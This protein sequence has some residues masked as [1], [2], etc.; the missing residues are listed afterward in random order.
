M[1]VPIK[2]RLLADPLSGFVGFF[3]KEGWVSRGGY[4][5]RIYW[6]SIPVY[7]PEVGCL[8][9]LDATT[10]E[11]TTSFMEM[12]KGE[13]A[14][15][16]LHNFEP[17]WRRAVSWGQY[18]FKPL[19]EL[20]RVYSI[21]LFLD[22]ALTPS[23]WT[24][25]AMFS[26]VR[27]FPLECHRP[28]WFKCFYSYNLFPAFINPE[29]RKQKKEV[30]LG[31]S[32]KIVPVEVQEIEF[33]INGWLDS[34]KVY[35][36]FEEEDFEDFQKWGS[37]G[38]YFCLAEGFNSYQGGR[39]P[40]RHINIVRALYPLVHSSYDI[41]PLLFPKVVPE[42]EDLIIRFFIPTG[43]LVRILHRLEKFEGVR[44]TFQLE[45]SSKLYLGLAKVEEKEGKTIYE[46]VNPALVAILIRKA[47]ES[48]VETTVAKEVL[49]KPWEL[50]DRVKE[51][52]KTKKDWKID[53]LLFGA[54][55]YLSIKTENSSLLRYK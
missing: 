47:L 3:E 43:S 45:E 19:G 44:G 34:K 17:S 1:K 2:Q 28:L 4:P 6:A 40:G 39:S 18:E 37:A 30:W 22:F 41:M 35:L 53:L 48:R 20:E 55:E 46:A 38:Y 8:I 27:Y 11:I 52:E 32:I 50:M 24:R 23:V 13:V 42:R 29:K 16:R 31:R 33:N 49:S 26:P 14:I 54:G 7:L 10:P 25:G 15:V 5:I 36:S 51:W 9:S 21:S 12:G